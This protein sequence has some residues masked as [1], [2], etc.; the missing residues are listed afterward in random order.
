M[1]MSSTWPKGRE[2]LG[3]EQHRQQ[4]VGRAA[5]PPVTSADREEESKAT[6]ASLTADTE[7]SV[8]ALGEM[9]LAVGAPV[10]AA[11]AVVA[12]CKARVQRGLPK[13]PKTRNDALKNAGGKKTTTTSPRSSS[14]RRNG[15]S[16]SLRVGVV[17]LF[18]YLMVT[19]SCGKRPSVFSVR[20]TAIGNR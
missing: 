1:R 9:L 19:M 2:L 16:C 4:L 11:E 18:L 3:L 5:R 7:L 8:E 13:M 10:E 17:L 6:L 20:W 12:G 15:G 14:N